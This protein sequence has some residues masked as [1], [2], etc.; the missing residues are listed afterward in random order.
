MLAEQ[1][2]ELSGS[3]LQTSVAVPPRGVAVRLER[4]VVACSNL[5]SLSLIR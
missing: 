4:L 2:I 1:T 3:L 5:R